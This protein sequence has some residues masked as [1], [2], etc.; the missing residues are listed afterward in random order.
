MPSAQKSAFI[1][2]Q[3]AEIVIVVPRSAEISRKYVI[4]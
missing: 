2:M 4:I 3:K 1:F